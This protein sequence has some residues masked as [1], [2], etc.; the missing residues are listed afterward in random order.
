MTYPRAAS[1]AGEGR[2]PGTLCVV[3]WLFALALVVL[4]STAAAQ[5]DRWS[6]SAD[7]GA[8]WFFGNTRQSA[9]TTRL[10]AE[11]AD[12][13]LEF[14]A[15]ARHSYGEASNGDDTFVNKR[16]WSANVGID[17]WPNSKLTPF[18]FASFEQSLE[19]RISGRSSGGAGA[20]YV[21][22]RAGAKRLDV[23]LA[24]LAEHT[25]PRA[26]DGVEQTTKTIGRWSTRFRYENAT[27]DERVSFSAVTWYRPELADFANY[28]IDF[29]G[30]LGVGI[31]DTVS[32]KMSLIDRFDSGAI[33]R[34]A[35]SNTDG[36]LLVGIGKK[37]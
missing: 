20:K 37:F 9:F 18:G 10:G 13:V 28:T 1:T 5:Q 8:S 36:Q 26:R 27:S 21:I 32:L 31:S 33:E 34:G 6:A 22:R 4:P 25:R 11:R 17:V 15:G 2:T 24:V 23:S 16:S 3:G 14:S 12:S 29:E 19:Q 35:T 7:V 30:A